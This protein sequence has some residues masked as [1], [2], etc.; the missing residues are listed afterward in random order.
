LDYYGKIFSE[1]LAKLNQKQWSGKIA[2]PK[3]PNEHA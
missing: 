3:T 2:N 1:S